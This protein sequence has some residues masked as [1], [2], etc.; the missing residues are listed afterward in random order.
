MPIVSKIAGI[1]QEMTKWRRDL[2]ANPELGLQETRT[3]DVVQAN[4]R[5]FGVDE[6]ITGLAL[7]GVVGV[8]HGSRKR[9]RAIG[10]RAEFDALPIHEATGLPY[11]SQHDG[12]MHA[13][14]HDGHTAML[15]GAARY[16]A[17]TRNF[18]GTVYAIFQPAE[19]GLGGGA[20][21]V[22]EG[23]FERC[24]ME[25]VFG[26]HN[27]PQLPA[28]TFAWREGPIMA[29]GAKIEIT[30]TGKGSHGAFPHLGIDP[31][32]I[33]SYVVCALQTIVARKIDP[34][35][36]GVATI[37]QINAGRTCNVIPETVHMLGT[38]RWFNPR[39]GD[40]SK[41]RSVASPRASR[42]ALVPK[43]MWFSNT[44]VLRRS[45]MRMR[46]RSPNAQP[47]LWSER[48][49]LLRCGTRPWPG[50]TSHSC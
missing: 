21:M 48:H 25:M 30:I 15:L 45:M 50:R 31:I 1:H 3:S 17:E 29:G 33:A 42:K 39:V 46:P 22:K 19:E 5:R 38:A 14:G 12:V 13:C 36:S 4:L 9:S 41:T 18:D 28:G 44:S 47:R 32:V 27:W 26:M 10:L 20:T 43:L 8:I 7:T 11:A 6:I 24:P 23:L 49:V 35:E 40:R 37:G 34:A 2:H 16:L